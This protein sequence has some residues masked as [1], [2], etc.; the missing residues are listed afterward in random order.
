M[1]A[2]RHIVFVCR[3]LGIHSVIY[4]RPRILPFL[5]IH[6]SESV[7]QTCAASA[8]ASPATSTVT[9]PPSFNAAATA[10]SVAGNS[11]CALCSAITSV[12]IWPTHVRCSNY[13][14]NAK[15][16]KQHESYGLHLPH[17][18]EGRGGV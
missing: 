9:G 4:C 8:T 18:E 1:W 7:P 16:A 13:R 15:T 2:A 10:G 3:W 12:L 17:E 6:L 5:D 11:R 14:W